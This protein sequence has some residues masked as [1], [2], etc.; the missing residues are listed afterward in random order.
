MPERSFRFT[1][2]II[3][4]PPASAVN[5]LRAEDVGNPDV[6]VMMAHHDSYVHALTQAGLEVRV[7][8]ALEDFPDSLFVED[9]ALCLHEGA[10]VLRPGAPTRFGESLAMTPHLEEVYTEVRTLQGPGFIEGGDIL[11]T[12]SEIL[13]GKS[14]RTNSEGIEELRRTVADWGYTVREVTTPPGVLHFKSDCSLLDESTILSTPRL[15]QSGCFEGYTVIDVA[16]GEEPAA[17][18]IRVNDVVFMPR[19]FPLTTERVREA[20]FVVIELENSECQKIDGGLSCLS[21]RF[22][23]R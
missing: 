23:P 13:V 19:G 17:N 16:E 3:R 4:T 20:G 9:T 10:I 14:E 8:D 11:T 18:S 2:A 15:S 1:H 21:L 5:G 6:G 7:L 22:T 12:E